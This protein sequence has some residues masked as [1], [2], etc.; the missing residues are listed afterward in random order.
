MSR[1]RLIHL[2]GIVGILGLLACSGVTDPR[3]RSD[4]GRLE[5]PT[6]GPVDSL[7]F[8]EAWSGR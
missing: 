4:D 7:L 8:A 6:D 1:E 5:S 3:N 2:A